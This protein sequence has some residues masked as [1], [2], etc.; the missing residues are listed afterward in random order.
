MPRT[1]VPAPPAARW[2]TWEEKLDM[3]KHALECASRVYSGKGDYLSNEYAILNLSK[4]F[5]SYLK[6]E[7]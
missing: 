7:A 4:F 5:E 1:Y 6:G 3:R 2:D